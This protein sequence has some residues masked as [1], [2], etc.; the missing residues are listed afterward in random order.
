MESVGLIGVGLV[1][2]ALA[3]RLR[4]CGYGVVGFDVNVERRT[5]LGSLGGMTVASACQVAARTRRI[6]LSL[7]DTSVV[8][9]VIEGRDG[10][11]AADALPTHLID[12]TTSDPD[13]TVALA[14]RLR[15]R[16]ISLLDA[17]ISGSS[18]QV[19]L[20]QAVFMVGGDAAACAACRDLFAAITDR[21]FY[22]GSSGSGSKAK[23]A[24]NLLLGLNRL[25]LAEGLVFAERLGLDAEAFLALVRE[26][27]AYS[28]AVDA[29]GHKMAAD[30]F[31][32]ES[33]VRQH[34]KDLT[35]I[36]NYAEQKGQALPLAQVHAA[37][38]DGLIAQGEGDLDNAAVIREIR[39]RTQ[40]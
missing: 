35:L 17:T 37:I 8:R 39:R 1:G 36:L 9:S 33:R 30:D 28:A 7:P 27:P 5:L 32:P 3:E 29:K 25:A 11:L 40:R 23:L 15:E 22:L 2:I 14:E 12:T 16:G 13:E 19:R 38:L 24:T 31:S 26:T 21:T 20:G 18:R 34:R 4:G 6:L 10:I